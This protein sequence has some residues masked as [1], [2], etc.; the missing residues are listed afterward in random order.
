MLPPKPRRRV[1]AQEIRAVDEFPP[2]G[3][4]QGNLN[5]TPLVCFQTAQAGADVRSH[6]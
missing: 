4:D 2:L 1:D 5:L 6:R 3:I